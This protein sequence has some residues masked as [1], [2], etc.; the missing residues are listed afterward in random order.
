MLLFNSGN[1]LSARQEAS[2][3]ARMYYSVLMTTEFLACYVG[4]LL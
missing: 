4:K 2:V 1:E 3:V